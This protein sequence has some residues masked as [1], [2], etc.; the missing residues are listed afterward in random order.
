MLVLSAG[1]GSLFAWLPEVNLTA[2]SL[3]ASAA[4][5]AV[6]LLPAANAFR[7]A[8]RLPP[9][10]KEH[11][12]LAAGASFDHGVDVDTTKEHVNRAA[13][14]GCCV[15]ACSASWIHCHGLGSGIRT[16]R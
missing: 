2:A 6:R 13:D 10:V 16:G 14:R 11:A 15:S 3:L 9:N 8:H 4:V 5:R 1:T 7:P 12:P